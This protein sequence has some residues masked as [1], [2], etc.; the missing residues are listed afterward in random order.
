MSQKTEEIAA[1]MKEKG[2]HFVERLKDW[3][4]PPVDPN[5]PPVSEDIKY[6]PT[7]LAAFFLSPPRASFLIIRYTLILFVLAVVWASLSKIDE[8]TNGEG[9]VIPSSHVQVIQNLEGGIVSEIPVKIGQVVRKEQIVLKLDET[10]FA[11]SAG[12]TK[13]KTEALQAKIARLT[14]EAS[15]S[16]QIDFPAELQESNP[17]I[18]ADEMSL[19]SSRK[20]EFEATQ[21]VLR[22]QVAQRNQELVEKHSNLTHLQ[23]TYHIA[24]KELQ[25]S[26]PLQKQGVV[27]EVEIL[28]L[29]RDVTRIRSE[30][31]ATRLAIP[32][33]QS[34]AAEA[35]NKLEG[36]LAKFR[37]DAANELAHAKAEYAGSSAT[38]LAAEDRLARTTVR[39]PVD[40]IVK[41]I[42]VNTVGGVIQPGMDVMEIVPLE[43]NLLI[44]A[45]IRPS[46]VGFLRPGQEANVKI[47]AYDYS[48][49]GGLDGVVENIS[50][51]SITNEKG[52]SFYLVQV[53]TKKNHL[54]TEEKPLTII[55]GMMANVSIKTGSKSIMSYLMKPILKTK[56]NALTER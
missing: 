44:E 29:Q 26:I 4:L 50:A 1:E 7:K 11:S 53:R 12:E 10:R 3:A 6:M 23:S 22:E 18:V 30:M 14:A 35:T 25:M 16:E 52:E 8:M 19:F 20:E 15:G 36:A 54:G 24:N 39:S 49:Y 21:N 9:K 13:A 47:S 2:R 33:L 48:I 41:T 31:D 32:R 55:P 43:D 46:D 34:Q 40:G 45:K 27:S 42:K 38:G 28:R 5:A 51:D 17:Q 56:Q 37:S